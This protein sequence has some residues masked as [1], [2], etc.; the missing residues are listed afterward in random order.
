LLDERQRV[1]YPDGDQ[2]EDGRIFITYD[3]DRRG[4]REILFAVFTEEDVLAGNLVSEGSRL[5]ALINKT[6]E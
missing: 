5:R 4:A 1:S 2:A 3:F 6:G